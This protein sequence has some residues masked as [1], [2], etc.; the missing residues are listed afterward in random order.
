VFDPI[1]DPT[2]PYDPVIVPRRRPVSVAVAGM[3]L[4]GAGAVGLVAA[5]ALLGAAGPVVDDFRRYAMEMGVSP[6]AAADIARAVRTALLSGG[7]GALAL[8]VLSVPLGRGVMRRSE[9]ARIGALVVAGAS[10][11]CG[12]VRTSLTA[13]GG[14]VDWSAAAGHSDPALSDGVAQA[15]ADAMPG[16]LVGLG[17]GL[18]DLQALGYIAVAVLLLAPSSRE[19]FRTRLVWYADQ[20]E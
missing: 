19:Y 8:A 11:G 1:K 14:S 6:P 12:L 16:W 20:L 7:C 13:F 18:T 4:Y 10:L 3:A 5:L 9:P 15:F 17:G 2:Q